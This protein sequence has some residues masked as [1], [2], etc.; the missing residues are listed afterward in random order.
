VDCIRSHRAFFCAFDSE[1]DAIAK[2]KP[3]DLD[4]AALASIALVAL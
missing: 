1:D 3:T 2:E 4:S